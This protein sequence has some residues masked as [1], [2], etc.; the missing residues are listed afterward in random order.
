[1]N[2]S[3]SYQ[4]T[5]REERKEAGRDSRDKGGG[6]GDRKLCPPVG[7]TIFSFNEK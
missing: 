4:V 5:V 3:E 6:G 7:V 2:M 1:M